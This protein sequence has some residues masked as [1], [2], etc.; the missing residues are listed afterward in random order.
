M[1]A[2]DEYHVPKRQD[3]EVLGI[4]DFSEADI[5]AIRHSEP[6]RES[7]VFNEELSV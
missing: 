5:E 6:S 2:A 3:R 1:T 7:E 4:E